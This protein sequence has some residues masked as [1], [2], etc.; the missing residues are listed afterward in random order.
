MASDL[1]WKSKNYLITNDNIQSQTASRSSRNLEVVNGGSQF[2]VKVTQ[3]GKRCA[4][5]WMENAKAKTKKKSKTSLACEALFNNHVYDEQMHFLADLF[6]RAMKDSSDDISNFVVPTFDIPCFTEIKVVDGTVSQIYHGHPTYRGE[7]SWH[8]WV[9][10]SWKCLDGRMRK[11][12]AE[13][14]FFI[15]VNEQLFPYAGSISGYRGEGTYTVI[16]SMKEEPN[17]F[18]SSQLLSQ[19][20]CETEDEGECTKNVF[21]F[22]WV[23]SFVNPA[24]VIDNIGCPNNSLFVLT[25]R[26]EWAKEFL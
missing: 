20:I 14:I 1:I 19:G 26:S 18:G 4:V 2:V 9:N 15:D 16:H 21:H 7:D 10:V 12:P 5:E 24:F 23:N 3:R 11:V 22:Q 8:D 13:I 17:T 6:V 25:P